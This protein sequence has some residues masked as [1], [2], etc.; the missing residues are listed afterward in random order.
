[1]C[2]IL[3][4]LKMILEPKTSNSECIFGDNCVLPCI[5]YSYSSKENVSL[6]ESAREKTVN[7][8][9]NLTNLMQKL[10]EQYDMKIDL[11]RESD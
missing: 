4:D 9:S 6:R 1:M 11:N 8:L 2:F 10:K 5:E 3:G 7:V